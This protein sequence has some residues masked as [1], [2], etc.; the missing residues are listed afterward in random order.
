MYNCLCSEE[1]SSESGDENEA[2]NYCV[3]IAEVFRS[4]SVDE[5]ADDFSNDDALR[6]Y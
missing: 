6:R 2:G 1:D 3:A 5:E 4:I